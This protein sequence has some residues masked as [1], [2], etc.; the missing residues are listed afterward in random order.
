[1]SDTLARHA[2]PIDRRE[3]TVDDGPAVVRTAS[4]RESADAFKRRPA[5]ADGGSARDTRFAV[6]AE[7]APTA[8]ATGDPFGQYLAALVHRV[9]I[10]PDRP[11]AFV[12]SALFTCVDDGPAST[13]VPANVAEILAT[14]VP[15][16]ICLVDANFHLPSL[17]QHYGV[18][19]HPGLA[20]ALADT[21]AFAAY[22]RQVAIDGAGSLHFIPAGS[23]AGDNPLSNT[24]AAAARMRDLVESFDYVIVAAPPVRRYPEASLLGSHV[25]GVVLIAEANVTRRQAARSAADTLRA[26]GAQLLGTVLTNRSFPIPEAVYRLL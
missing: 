7:R 4:R 21:G 16:Q 20:Q 22:A 8:G 18:T 23:P 19:E 1:M 6:A 2:V 14:L 5:T 10:A 24:Y 3:Q 26:A 17:H 12:R 11:D 9:F 25:D 15:G 13:L